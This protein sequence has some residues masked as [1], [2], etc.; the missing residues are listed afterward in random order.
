M[1]VMNLDSGVTEVYTNYTSACA[2]YLGDVLVWSAGT[3]APAPTPP[4]PTPSSDYTFCSGGVWSSGVTC[5]ITTEV[6]AEMDFTARVEA[7]MQPSNYYASGTKV[8]HTGTF[9]GNTPSQYAMG[10]YISTYIVEFGSQCLKYPEIYWLKGQ[11][12]FTKAK[13]ELKGTQVP[14]GQT[15]DYIFNKV[16]V[17]DSENNPINTDGYNAERIGPE[18][19]WIGLEA[20]PIHRIRFWNN[21]VLI[22]DGQAAIR[23]SDGQGGLYDSVSDTFYTNEDVAIVEA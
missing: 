23:N 12:Q 20:A 11:T 1:A 8:K 18:P 4:Q 13:C 21:D 9:F 15:M 5:H 16:G 7:N 14:W 6:G 10:C 19:L 17:Y 22:F 3:P 2:M